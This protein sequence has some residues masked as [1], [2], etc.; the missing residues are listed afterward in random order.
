MHIISRIE[1]MGAHVMLYRIVE[2]DNFG[3]DYPN[4]SFLNIGALNWE[5]S[6]AIAK[7]IND[8]FGPNY[9]RYWQVVPDDYALD[10][11]TDY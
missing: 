7:A 6:K 3:G 9:P 10:T 1:K 5:H 4:E 11:A 2:T 8:G